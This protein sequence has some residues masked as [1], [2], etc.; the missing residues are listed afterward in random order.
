MSSKTGISL[1][2]SQY[3]GKPLPDWLQP[4]SLV[5]TSA[6]IPEDDEADR[7]NLKEIICQAH[8]KKA[9]V[10]CD[11]DGQTPEEFGFETIRDFQKALDIDILR[12]DDGFSE[13]EML[14][15]AAI[16]PIAI[17]ASTTS[18]D[19]VK[20]LL[21]A[22]G[23]TLFVHNF[24]PRPETGLDLE[25]FEQ[26]NEAIP[27]ENLV[28]FVN[29]DE[30][31]RG[32]LYKGLVTLEEQRH[33]PVYMNWRQM[34]HLGID[35]IL[36]AD[37][38]VSQKQM[39]LILKDQEGLTSI[40]AVLDESS[41]DLY[42]VPFTIRQ[43]SPKGLKRLAESRAYGK[44]GQ[45]I[46]PDH[47]LPRNKGSITRDNEKYGRYSGE[48]MIAARDYPADEK[49][50][51]IGHILEGWEDLSQYV[52]NGGKIQFVRPKLA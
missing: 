40:P 10:V 3:K 29:G 12:L 16:S 50:N 27:P 42:G 44:K 34:R 28:V 39:D 1:Y 51:V 47:T 37:P 20:K 48:I 30:E 45:P 32:P 8:E 9:L 18:K 23:N 7:Q 13:E 2:P 26:L 19:M 5:F 6:H 46:V 33:R 38:G 11:V 43:D 4:G 35:H 25:T 15:L 31:L 17:N 36:I 52:D 14:E 49:V 22:N 24:Y 21:A 41:Q